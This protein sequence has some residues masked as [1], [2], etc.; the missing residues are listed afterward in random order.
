MFEAND[1][2]WLLDAPAPVEQM[3]NLARRVAY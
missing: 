1:R 2:V 3:L